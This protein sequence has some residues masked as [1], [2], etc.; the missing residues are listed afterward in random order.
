MPTLETGTRNAAVD[1][2]VDLVDD[3]AGAGSLR[4]YTTGKGSLL[5][6]LPM[7]DPAFGSASG[8]VATANSIT[9]DS[10]ADNTGTAAEFDF[11]DS[12]TNIVLSGTVGTSGAELNFNSVEFSAG[13]TVS[14]SSFTVSIPAS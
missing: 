2:V 1:A 12:D 4:V 6:T 9:D 13:Q 10:S 11:I 14:V 5:A 3:G 7:S 8:G